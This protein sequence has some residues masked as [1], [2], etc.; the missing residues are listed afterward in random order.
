[1][2]L[3]PDNLDKMNDIEIAFDASVSEQLFNKIGANI[4][5]LISLSGNFQIFTAG[6]TWDVP[7]GIDQVF[8]Y[9]AGGGGGGGGGHNAPIGISSGGGGGQGVLPTAAIL[10]GIAFGETY[11]ITI[12][13]GGA[14]GADGANG[15]DGGSTIF[16]GT[17]GTLTFYGGVSGKSGV[18]NA[19]A[20]VGSNDS[21]PAGGVLYSPGGGGAAAGTRSVYAAGGAAGPG[22]TIFQAGGGGG[23]GLDAGGNGAG[24]ASNAGAGTANG[25]NGGGGGFG[26]GTGT[27]DNGAAGGSGLLILTW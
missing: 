10:T 14:G 24:N 7:E 17:A 9:G 6:D 19:A 13:A 2:A 8:V 22:G 16:S 23:A 11:T 20:T 12:G 21:V 5:G 3:I 27:F 1:M 25:C 26:D 18:L 4:N 15:G